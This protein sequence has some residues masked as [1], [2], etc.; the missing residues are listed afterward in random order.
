V[1]RAT[2]RSSPCLND[3]VD[4]ARAEAALEA[5]WHHVK[6]SLKEDADT[7]SEWL[8]LADIVVRLV[9]IAEDEGDLARTVFQNSTIEQLKASCDRAG[10]CPPTALPLAI[11][12]ADFHS[13]VRPRLASARSPR[14]P[15]KALPRRRIVTDC[16]A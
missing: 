8:R 3:P 16:N 1:N 7:E 10:I 13:I 12:V 4:I 15:A 11:F 2:I 14:C 9:P 5:G 6:T